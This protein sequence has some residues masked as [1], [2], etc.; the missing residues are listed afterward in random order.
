M[1]S[2]RAVSSL[3]PRDTD[4]IKGGYLELHEMYRMQ[5]SAWKCVPW[6]VRFGQCVRALGGCGRPTPTDC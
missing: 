3:V 5:Q 2:V 6:E 1:L 4:G